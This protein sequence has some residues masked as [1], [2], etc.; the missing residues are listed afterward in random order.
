MSRI[1]EA[2]IKL[3]EGVTFEYKD[4][5]L[6]VEGP[7]GKLHKHIDFDGDIQAEDN[8]VRVIA[9]SSERKSRAFQGLVRALLNNMVVGVSRGFT[10]TLKIVGVGYKVQ[11][12][13]NKLVLNVGYS[14][15][16]EY[17]VPEG[18]KME[19]PDPNT[20]VVSGNDK[21]LVGQVT[22]NLRK[23]RP[24]EP[25]KGKGIMYADERIKRKAGKAGIK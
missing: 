11:L 4:S 20:V 7:R 6:L 9:K 5:M 3:P 17:A 23:F 1:G 15:P 19:V 2:V 25:Y 21:Q 16:I 18:I 13:G 12:Q 22:A 8:T 24:P 10:L 14:H